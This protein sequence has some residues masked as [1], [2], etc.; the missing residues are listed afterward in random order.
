MAAVAVMQSCQTEYSYTAVT[1]DRVDIHEVVECD[2]QPTTDGFEQYSC[3]PVFSN[4]DPGTGEWERAA[5]GD[6]DIVQREVFGA[7]FYQMWYSGRAGDGPN[8]G[9]HVGYA[10][11][12]DGVDW[13]R[14]PYNPVLRRGTNAGSFDRA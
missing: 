2:F 10:V 3:V 12:M 11:S 14:H 6:F 13:Q 5:I 7:P 1:V 4:K 9:E 8:D